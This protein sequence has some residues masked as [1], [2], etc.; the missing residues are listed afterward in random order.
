MSPLGICDWTVDGFALQSD[1]A[2]KYL[3]Y[4]QIVSSAFIQATAMSMAW[5]AVIPLG[6]GGRGTEVAGGA[7]VDV[8]GRQFAMNHSRSAVLLYSVP[9]IAAQSRRSSGR[10]G[11]AMVGVSSTAAILLAVG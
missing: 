4:G 7:S 8:G 5:T 2:Q 9:R 6:W 3:E 1:S 10:V 11:E